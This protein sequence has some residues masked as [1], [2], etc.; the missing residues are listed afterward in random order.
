MKCEGGVQAGSHPAT[1]AATATAATT[2]TT[3]AATATAAATTNPPRRRTRKPPRRMRKPPRRTTCRSRR[4]RWKNQRWILANQVTGA[5]RMC[6]A[7]LTRS[8]RCLPVCPRRHRFVCKAFC[9]L[10]ALSPC[11]SVLTACAANL[12]HG[13]RPGRSK[14]CAYSRDEIWEYMVRTICGLQPAILLETNHRSLLPWV[15]KYVVRDVHAVS[16]E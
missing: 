15:E 4:R 9:T 7:C 6:A 1:T 14:L 11:M 16:A 8:A 5:C 12:E 10:C 2:T 13:V 3:A